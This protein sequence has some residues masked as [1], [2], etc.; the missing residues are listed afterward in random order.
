MKNVYTTGEV[1]RI[2]NVTIRTVIKWFESGELE[3]FKIPNSRDRRIP[4]D[5]LITFMKKHGIPLKNIDLDN[6]KRILIA[7][8]EEGIIFVLKKFLGDIGIFDIDTASSG[9]ETGMKL[10]SFTPHL[11]LLDHLLGDTTSKEVVS[12]VKR[13]PNLSGLRIIIMSGYVSD[14]EVEVMLQD[15]INDFIRKPFDLDVVKAKVFQQLDLA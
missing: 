1:A 12:N 7:D 6:R 2:C 3:G 9:L 15:G 14:D 8:D 4:R 5:S 10:A 13:D 11:L